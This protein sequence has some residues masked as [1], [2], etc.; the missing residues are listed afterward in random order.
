MK[1]KIAYTSLG[2]FLGVLITVGVVIGG[3]AFA[4][5]QETDKQY[6]YKKTHAQ[7]K[8]DLPLEGMT[9]IH[10]N[11]RDEFYSAEQNINKKKTFD[12]QIKKIEKKINDYDNKVI[13]EEGKIEIINGYLTALDDLKEV[14]E[15]VSKGQHVNKGIIEDIHYNLMENHRKIAKLEREYEEVG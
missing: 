3:K 1:M 6:E 7:K 12:K 2:L 11:I 15:K 9:D 5:K 8:A 10:K 14:N 13:I 4:A